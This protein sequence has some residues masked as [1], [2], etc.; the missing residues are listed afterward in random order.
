MILKIQDLKI[1]IAESVK[2]TYGATQLDLEFVDLHYLRPIALAGTVERDE[3]IVTLRGRLIS[4]LEQ[5]CARCLKQVKSGLNIPFDFAYP[6]EGRTSIDATGDIRDI[7]YLNHPERFLCSEECRG[8]CPVCG[9]NLNQSICDC[10]QKKV[11]SIQNHVID[12]KV[13]NLLKKE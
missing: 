3:E 8:L 7:L 6:I 5:V 13:L 2:T 4:Q 9:I 10:S 1:G 11:E 12:E